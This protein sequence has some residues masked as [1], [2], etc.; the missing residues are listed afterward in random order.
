MLTRRERDRRVREIAGERN[1]GA[2]R[3]WTEDARA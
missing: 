3:A 1:E 2:F